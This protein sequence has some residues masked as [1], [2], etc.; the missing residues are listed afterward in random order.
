MLSSL[1]LALSLAP[2]V[3]PIQRDWPGGPWTGHD[4]DKGKQFAKGS[5]VY[6]P[7]KEWDAYQ[8]A[9]SAWLKGQPL[10]L[11]DL[12]ATQSKLRWELFDLPAT[13]AKLVPTLEADSPRMTGTAP[14][15]TCG[16]TG[17]VSVEY[18][19]PGSRAIK[20]VLND[21][22]FTQMGDSIDMPR[23]P[24]KIVGRVGLVEGTITGNVGKF[25]GTKVAVTN[26]TI[27]RMELTA[28]WGTG[29]WNAVAETKYGTQRQSGKMR[30]VK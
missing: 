22:D 8:R 17:S 30:A 26:G 20:V 15:T 13:L 11:A 7:V 10:K 29:R 5:F 14:V 3:A 12:Q 19:W 2:P 1:I 21:L 24:I 6:V 4:A 16:G 28:D 23:P 25:V 18:A 27:S 9:T